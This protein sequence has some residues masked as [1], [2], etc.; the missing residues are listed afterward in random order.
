M[1]R[2]SDRLMTIGG[3]VAPGE[4]MADI[5]TDHGYLPLFLLN[6]GIS[7]KAIATDVSLGSVR[8]AENNY[9]EIN[10][11]ED[12]EGYLTPEIR[13]GNGLEPIGYSEV[14]DIV[15]AGMGGQTIIEILDWDIHKTRSYKKLI[16]HPTNNGGR[17]RFYLINKGFSIITDRVV[18]E[19]SKFAEIIEAIP[20][21]EIKSRLTSTMLSNMEKD[22]TFYDYPESIL[23]SDREILVDYLKSKINEESKVIEHI[24]K[25]Q[26]ENQG[27]IS[28]CQYREKRI[29]RLE[30]LL[31]EVEAK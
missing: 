22:F 15:I 5:G 24:K 23:N 16:L 25:N 12:P 29:E 28:A 18:R 21:Q 20:S 3:L 19:K 2:L 8:K 30:R 14:D 9:K 17:V 27:T 13:W 4:S 7:P 10:P 11:D 26:E 1:N 31:K 6:E